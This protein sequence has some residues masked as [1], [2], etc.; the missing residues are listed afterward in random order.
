MILCDQSNCILTKGTFLR[1]CYVSLGL[2]KVTVK[3]TVSLTYMAKASINLLF[4]F[5]YLYFFL[6]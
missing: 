2:I 4:S 1:I 5:D 3:S 6:D